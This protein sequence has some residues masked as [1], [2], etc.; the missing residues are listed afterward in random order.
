M[1]TIRTLK[2]AHFSGLVIF[3]GSIFTFIVNFPI[4]PTRLLKLIQSHFV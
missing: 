3:L 1:K 4:Q 2:L